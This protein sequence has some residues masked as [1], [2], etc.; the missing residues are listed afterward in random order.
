MQSPPK[1][2]SNRD[3]DLGFRVSNIPPSSQTFPTYSAIEAIPPR[4]LPLRHSF[5]LALVIGLFACGGLIC[6]VLL[7]DNNDELTTPRYWPR[8]I[9]S[10]PAGR[11]PHRPIAAPVLPQ[12]AA[13]KRNANL[14]EKTA[15][16]QEQRIG[17]NTLFYGRSGRTSPVTSVTTG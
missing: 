7:F 6:S 12:N 13:P 8:E 5:Q 16:L 3:I 17:P 1:M 9:Y 11:T 15:L 4:K 14:E 2:P 10:S